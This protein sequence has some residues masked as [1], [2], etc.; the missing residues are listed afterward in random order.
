MTLRARLALALLLLGGLGVLV[1][2]LLETPGG[3]MV[4]T[5]WHSAAQC[6]D[7]HAEL[8]AEWHGSQHQLAFLNPEVRALSDDFRNENCAACH[9]PQPVATT[10]YGKNTLRRRTQPDEGISCLTCHLGVAGEILGRAARPGAPCA[11]VASAELVSVELCASCHNQHQTTDQ[12]R[13]SRFAAEGTACNDCHMP[14]VERGG[15]EGRA[16][17][18]PATRDLEV[19]R[20]AARLSV[21]RDGDELLIALENHGAGHNFPTEERHRAVD[22]IVRFVDGGGTAG[23][24]QPLYRFRQPYR[25]EPGENTQLP[26]GAAHRQRLP[27]PAGASRAQVRVWYRRTPFVGDE[28]P[29]SL[30]LFEQELELS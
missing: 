20:G 16:H 22:L 27:I 11:P 18:Y 1:A 30:L 26:A 29:R 2:F 9:L 14:P 24:W 12:W 7:C 8:F 19:L 6:R 23:E 15:R 17:R 3:S 13:A 28:D 21:T 5:R 4:V 10:G 25:D